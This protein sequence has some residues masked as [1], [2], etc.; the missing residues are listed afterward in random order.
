LALKETWHHTSDDI[1]LN[2][3]VP[4]SYSIVD[5]TRSN[6]NSTCSDAEQGGDIAIIHGIRFSANKF[7]RDVNTTTFEVLCCLLYSAFVTV[8]HVVIYRPGTKPATDGF[9]TEFIAL[10]EI[11]ATFRNELIITIVQAAP[12]N[13][14]PLTNSSSSSQLFSGFSEYMTEE[15]RHVLVWSPLYVARNAN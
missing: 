15:V 14:N 7:K 3:C 5:V 1:L 2:S 10:L 9:F 11:T 8:V 13:V 12:V 6:A 4:P